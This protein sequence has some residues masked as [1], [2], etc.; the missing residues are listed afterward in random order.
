ML[1]FEAL[2]FKYF[3]D[4]IVWEQQAGFMTSDVVHT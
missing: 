4:P 2:T 3:L 1:T